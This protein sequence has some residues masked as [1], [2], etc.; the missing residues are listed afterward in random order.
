[1]PSCRIYRPIVIVSTGSGGSRKQL[2]QLR[3]KQ[4]LTH[5]VQRS[6]PRHRPRPQRPRARLKQHFPGLV[7]D[8]LRLHPPS[9]AR[10]LFNQ[11]DAL[12]RRKLAEIPCRCEPGDAAAYLPG[13]VRAVLVCRGGEEAEWEKWNKEQEEEKEEGL[14][15]PM[16]PMDSRESCGTSGTVSGT[17]CVVDWYRTATAAVVGARRRRRRAADW[18]TM[19]RVRGG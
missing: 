6:Q 14:E 10:R 12:P 13:C 2:H 17:M 4:V 18:R 8:A 1:M 5:H 19:A 9:Q 3:P 7:L 16:M 11:R 15:R